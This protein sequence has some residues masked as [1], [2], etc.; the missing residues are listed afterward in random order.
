M[1]ANTLTETEIPWM[2]GK[3]VV[4]AILDRPPTCTYLLIYEK[5]L[6]FY[7]VVSFVSGGGLLR[8]SF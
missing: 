1:T 6:M 8:L 2:V 5:I 4:D 7:N 3:R